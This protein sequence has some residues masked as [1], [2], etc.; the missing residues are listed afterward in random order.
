MVTLH[1]KVA[2]KQSQNN[3][4]SEPTLQNVILYVAFLRVWFVEPYPIIFP[5]TYLSP[6][7]KRGSSDFYYYLSTYLLFRVLTCYVEYN[8]AI[9]QVTDWNTCNKKITLSAQYENIHNSRWNI[10][11]DIVLTFERGVQHS[12]FDLGFLYH[13]G[14][15]LGEDELSWPWFETIP[16]V[17]NYRDAVLQKHRIQHN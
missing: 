5:V 11:Y 14:S 10:Y 17:F 13:I 9:C 1:H 3:T 6:K 16:I 4:Q 12:L 8:D 2:L 15:C 7:W